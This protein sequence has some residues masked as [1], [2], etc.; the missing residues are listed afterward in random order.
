M[1]GS[2]RGVD[3]FYFSA[4]CDEEEIFPISDEKYAQALQLQEALM[5][6]AISSIANTTGSTGCGCS[7]QTPTLTAPSPSPTEEIGQSSQGFCAI[8]MDMKPG[9]D[10]FTNNA[11]THSFCVD[12]IGKYVATKIHGNILNVEC[13]EPKC[14]GNL[15]PQLFRSVVPQEVFDRWENAL[16]ESL[17]LGS[18]KFYC[19]FKDCSALLLDDENEAAVT[20]SECPICHRLFC[21][22]CKVSWH[23]GLECEEFRKLGEGEREKEDI[24]MMELAKE[25]RWRRC[26]ACNFYV[27]KISGCLHIKCRLIHLCQLYIIEALLYI[28]FPCIFGFLLFHF[29]SWSTKPIELLM[30]LCILQVSI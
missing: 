14:K 20:V 10:M 21:A 24:M 7:N 2:E 5:S 30:A 9:G 4:L 18:R 19:P 27:E 22:R 16:C 12:C 6:S 23:A 29:L 28:H 3:E 25:K 15:E 13:P 26:P 1:E 8:C 11:C 17:V